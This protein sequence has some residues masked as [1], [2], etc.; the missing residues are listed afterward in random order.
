MDSFFTL[1]VNMIGFTG[2]YFK[3]VLSVLTVGLVFNTSFNALWSHVFGKLDALIVPGSQGAA[4]FQ[5]CSFINHLFPLDTMLTLIIAYG[6]VRLACAGIRMIKAW[7]PFVP[8]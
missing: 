2:P 8:T 3:T 4:N 6:G 1:L 5:P 7:I